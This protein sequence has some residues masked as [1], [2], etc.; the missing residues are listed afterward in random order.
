MHTK[1]HSY[2]YRSIFSLVPSYQHVN[3]TPASYHTFTKHATTTKSD[4]LRETSKYM[5]MTK[6]VYLSYLAVDLPS[7]SADPPK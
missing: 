5:S 3:S 7:N 6:L 2:D 1:F 4:S